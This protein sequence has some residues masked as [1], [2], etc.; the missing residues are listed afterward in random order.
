[1]AATHHQQRGTLSTHLIH[2]VM[3]EDR[4]GNSAPPTVVPRLKVLQ[5][6]VQGLR[7]KKHQVLQTIFEENLYIVL[8]QKTLTPADTQWRV[9][10]YIL[11]SLPT[12]VEG[13]RSCTTL[14][15]SSIPHRRTTNPVHCGDGVEA[16]AM[17]LQVGGRWFSVYNLYR[18]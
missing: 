13:S 6:N 5:W 16:L 18:S 15:R 7:P 3:M 1:M 4:D 11:H 9:A 2:I 14:V 12:S 17:E 10:G 8:L